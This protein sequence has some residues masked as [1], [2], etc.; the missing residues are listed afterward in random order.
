MPIRS[1]LLA[2]TTT[3]P[4]ARDEIAAG[5]HPRIDYLDLQTRLDADL[6]DF[7]VYD[8]APYRWLERFDRLSRL[9]WGQAIHAL[10]HWKD[11]EVVYSLGEDV[12]VPLAFLLRLWGLR[13]RHIMVAHN[14]LSPRKVSVIRAMHV[15]GSFDRIV[16]FSPDAV[17]GI[18]GTFGVPPAKIA[19]TMDAIDEHFWC[20]DSVVIPDPDYAISVGRARRDFATLMTAVDG[21]PLRLRVQAG[22]QW[23][24]EYAVQLGARLPEN[25]ELGS[26]L[27]YADLRELYQRAGFIV[28]PLEP[29]AHHSAGSV[30]IKEAMAMEKAVILAASDESIYVRE[31]ETGL[32]VP[33]GDAAALRQAIIQLLDAPDLARRMGTNGRALLEREMRYES[34][35]DWLAS[36]AM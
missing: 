22:S 16:V 6:I 18:A 2:T 12:G 36:L 5:T 11:Y 29:G 7:G 31:G 20:N 35:I 13:P 19:F 1:L 8:H 32:R 28:I 14:I 30:S 23:H 26:Y 33:A 27:P 34:K 15:M 24:V 3:S 21:L 10:R 4:D 17:Q 25:V 9:A